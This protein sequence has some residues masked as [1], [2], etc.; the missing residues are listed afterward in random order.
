ML[1]ADLM[2]QVPLIFVSPVRVL[3]DSFIVQLPTKMDIKT[4]VLN[5]L[6]PL[7]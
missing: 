7:L 2:E 5:R 6:K 1:L 4:Q 3:H